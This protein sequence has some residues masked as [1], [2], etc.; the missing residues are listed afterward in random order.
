MDNVVMRL[1]KIFANNTALWVQKHGRETGYDMVSR[2]GENW[3]LADMLYHPIGWG[4]DLVKYARELYYGITGK[5]NPVCPKC[6]HHLS[7]EDLG[8]LSHDEVREL[9]YKI[10]HVSQLVLDGDLSRDC[11]QTEQTEEQPDPPKP[12]YYGSP[13]PLQ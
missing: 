4:H 1:W 2:S 10:A 12:D 11:G 7:R 5:P 8:F 9:C 13:E 6:G 3:N